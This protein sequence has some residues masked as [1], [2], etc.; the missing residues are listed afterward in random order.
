M[1]SKIPMKWKKHLILVEFG[2]RTIEDLESDI[3]RFSNTKQNELIEELKWNLEQDEKKHE[4]SLYIVSLI[5]IEEYYKLPNMLI[6]K[7][8]DLKKLNDRSISKNCSE[9]WFCKKILDEEKNHFVGRISIKNTWNSNQQV[10][11]QVWNGNHRNIEKWNDNSKVDYL[12]ASR[13]GWARR[14]QIDCIHAENNE[15]REKINNQFIE[16]I[17]EIE[18]HREKIETFI[19][20]LKSKE[21]HEICLEYMNTNHGIKFIDWDTSNDRLVIDGIFPTKREFTEIE[22]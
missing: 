12:R 11:E 4:K 20:Y 14:Y 19:N 15:L 5:P 18:C 22:R 8:E 21:I 17:K 3:H 6:E 10:V 2:L 16:A 9:I 7:K 13:D 1:D